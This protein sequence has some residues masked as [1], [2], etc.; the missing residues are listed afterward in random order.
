MALW[1][2]KRDD[3]P[4]PDALDR[5]GTES[6]HLDD[7]EHAWWAQEEVKEVWRP[8]PRRK[9]EP[10]PKRDILAE[11]FGVDWRTSFGFTPPSDQERRAEA[12]RAQ[13]PLD[14][15]DP[16]AVLEVDPNAS[17]DEIIAAHRYQARVHHPDLLFGQSA[18][19]K[20]E[21]EE[22][23]RIINAAYKELRIRRGM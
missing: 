14:E 2:R 21:S 1:T 10:E 7:D 19:E 22:R 3:P 15:Q 12:A 17:W 13:K 5:D 23:I 18:E 6:V 20:A 8:K 9:A 4:R 16:Y 11:H